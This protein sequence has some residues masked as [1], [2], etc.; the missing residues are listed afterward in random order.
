MT[1]VEPGTQRGTP[2]LHADDVDLEV[3]L[4]PLRLRN[5]IVPASGCFGSGQEIHQFFDVATLGAVVCKSITL[6]PRLGM[7]TPGMGET[8]SGMLNA[9]GLQNPGIDKWL[10]E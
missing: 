7:P 3:Q 9:I 1:A 10:A 4:G 2:P 5:P 8:A 6:E